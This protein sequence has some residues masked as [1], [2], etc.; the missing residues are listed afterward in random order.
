MW[1]LGTGMSNRLHSAAFKPSYVF[2][3]TALST[4]CSAILA[5][6]EMAYCTI[7]V[8]T[9]EILKLSPVN[10]N[11]RNASSELGNFV[12]SIRSRW[13]VFTGK[14]LF[15]ASAWHFPCEWEHPWE[16]A[17]PACLKPQL[18]WSLTVSQ[19]LLSELLWRPACS[20][21][22]ES[23]CRSG[24]LPSRRKGVKAFEQ[25]NQPSASRKHVTKTS[26]SNPTSLRA[27]FQIKCTVR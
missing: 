19:M 24:Y 2:I 3:L 18:W 22:H 5:Y 26:D 13:K 23:S 14:Y 8:M 7:K 27:A 1:I 11:D 12:I 21:P 6:I 15:P 20:C 17:P 9:E 10:F 4:C 25:K 16:T